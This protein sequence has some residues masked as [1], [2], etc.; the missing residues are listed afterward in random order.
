MRAKSVFVVL[1]ISLLLT[2]IVNGQGKLEKIFVTS[3]K[4]RAYGSLNNRT[5]SM[6]V[7]KYIHQERYSYI[8]IYDGE[9]I[10]KEFPE[11]EFGMFSP[12]GNYYSLIR[13]NF[14]EVYTLDHSLVSRLPIIQGRGHLLESYS[15]GFD[16]KYVYICEFGQE[17]IIYRYNVISGHKEE[18]LASGIYFH[19]VTV[20]D[21]N[22][23]YLLRN[24]T[25]DAPDYD[26]D[27]V[28][29]NLDS[30]TIETVDMSFEQFSIYDTFTISPD[31]K[32]VVFQNFDSYV[33]VVDLQ[34]GS[35]I[36]K[37]KLSFGAYIYGY[38]WSLDGS[39]VVF[40]ESFEN[41]YKY[42]ILY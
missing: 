16:E 39:S 8:S 31:E 34:E 20:A 13:D 6:L 22:I 15:W 38:S 30:K 23:L 29:Y 10:T 41:I 27:L 36:D 33:N 21:H 4:E 11:C 25:P 32:L 28:K 18:I 5:G 2:T 14:L 26:C 35:V 42:Y 9:L 7:N 24:K 12:K 17:T 19:P 3:G 1:L 40:A 37:F